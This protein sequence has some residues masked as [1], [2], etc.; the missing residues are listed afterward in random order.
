MDPTAGS[1]APAPAQPPAPAQGT[2]PVLASAGPGEE[3][4]RQLH[5]AWPVVVGMVGSMGLGIVD[6]IM[7]GAFGGDAIAAVALANLWAWGTAVIARNLP[8]GLDPI[9]AQAYGSGDRAGAGRALV[10][11]LALAALL[12]LPVALLHLVAAPGLRLLGQPA[13][14]LPLARVY[15]SILAPGVPLML[16][17]V[18]L[19]QFLQGLG[20]MRPATVAVL[21]GNV[22]NVALNWLLMHGLGPVPGL[23][24]VG[25]AI[26]SVL[27]MGFMLVLLVWLVRR[28]LRAWWPQT[29]RQDLRDW[30][31]LRAVGALGLPVGLQIAAE[32]WGFQ[33][34]GVM[35]GWLGADQLA[36]HTVTLNLATA[37]FMVPLGLS[38]AAATRVGNL[39][40][41]GQPW[42]RAA[43]VAVA[44]GG[45][46]MLLSA[47]LFTVL[48]EP[49]ARIYTRDVA[50]VALA[51][52]LI[53]VAAA[54]QLF[55]G[56]QVVGF[57][58]LRGLA[59]VRL[60]FA[61]SLV[62]F[63]GLGLPLGWF[64]CFPRG[65][66]ARGVWVGLALS[67]AA[68]TGML[69]LRIRVLHR[70]GVGALAT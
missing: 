54:F 41:A 66:G 61:M 28:E 56:V 26:S 55:D 53:P 13:E 12:S 6:T 44:T 27:G 63:W 68:V 8:K 23:G 59:D 46:V 45:A 2:L 9:V 65:L 24:P 64:L 57:G 20:I 33:A 17:L 1:S 67:L 34:A 52:S 25:C 70:R 49:L 31:A 62:A 37:A 10:H 4:R 38:A 21:L 29:W 15:C 19:R 42:G 22:V 3:L 39:V 69:L 11:G 30:P 50:V 60:P 7:V 16:A 36:A 5:L 58:V 32:T 40:G 35:V 43:V 47:F 14:L 51:A 48:P 18:T